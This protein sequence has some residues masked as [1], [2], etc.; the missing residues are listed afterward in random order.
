[1]FFRIFEILGFDSVLEM[2]QSFPD[3]IAI[4]GGEKVGIEIEP[5][6]SKF[7]HSD[8][9]I[10]NSRK[11]EDLARIY[12]GCFEVDDKILKE[13]FRNRGIDAIIE[14]KEF[15][16]YDERTIKGWTENHFR[17]MSRGMLY[18]LKIFME[19]NKDTLSREYLRKVAEKYP[20]LDGK[21]LGGVLSGFS[22]KKGRHWLVRPK[23]DATLEFN[24]IYRKYK[25]VVKEVLS[26]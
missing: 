7:D 13:E 17:E 6:A 15:L 18:I 21:K 11:K 26:D 12:I 2:R 3:I 19:G 24:P 23:T 25:N 14:L 9:Q 20:E 22:Q 4:E 1:M 8:E 5:V 16:R 10:S